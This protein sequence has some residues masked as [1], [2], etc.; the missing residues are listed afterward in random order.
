NP[1]ISG[2]GEWIPF[3]SAAGD[4]VPGQTQAP[5]IS[6]LFLARRITGEKIL[7]THVANAPA[8]PASGFIGQ[9][10]LSADGRFVVYAGTFTDV[11]PGMSGGFYQLFLYDRLAGTTSLVSHAAASPTTSSDD[12][13]LGAPSISADGRFAVFVSRATDLV[14]G[15]ADTNIGGDVFLYDRTTGAVTLISRQTG[16]AATAGDRPSA[17]PEISA[18]GRWIA[19]MSQATNLVPGQTD[20]TTGHDIFLHDRVTGTTTLVSHALGAPT[21]SAQGESG[22]PHLSADGRFLVFMGSSDNLT[23]GSISA[24]CQPLM[25]SC[26]DIYLHDRTTGENVLV[27]H[28]AASPT[29]SGGRKA[30]DPRISANGRFITFMS[31]SADHVPGVVDSASTRDTFLYDRTTGEI[32]LLSRRDDTPSVACGGGLTADP[33]ADGSRIVLSSGAPLLQ[34]DFNGLLDVYLYNNDLPGSSFFVLPPCRLFDTRRPEDGP[35]L[36]SGT[37]VILSVDGG[38]GIPATAQ[39]VNVTVFNPT[40]QGNLSIGPGDSAS[41]GTSTINFLP[42]VNRANNAIV[43]L[44]LDGS[45]SLAVRP[46][47]AGGGTVHVILDVVGHFE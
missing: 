7:I 36:V 10:D 27:S 40:G 37:P 30:L 6:A 44:A 3:A 47:V 15:Q 22:T 33:S 26:A 42:G 11:V 9:T 25:T 14:A 38:C 17:T 19:F 24:D 2:D 23:A 13:V 35:V 12:D 18:D 21:T 39:A 20:P 32:E 29:A 31:D 46:F 45:G 34:G 8:T 28:S 4:L 1:R 41:F 5:D 43:R 16:T